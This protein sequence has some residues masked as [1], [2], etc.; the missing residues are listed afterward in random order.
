MGATQIDIDPSGDVLAVL[1]ESDRP[2]APWPGTAVIVSSSQDAEA[3]GET[4]VQDQGTHY[5]ANI[6]RLGDL[7]N[8]NGSIFPYRAPSFQC[9][10]LF[11]APHVS[12]ATARQDVLWSVV[13][14]G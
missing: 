5:A 14:S 6:E 11:E 9:Q 1:Q 2:F 4:Q 8:N 3:G 13:G 12:L 10:T 7:V